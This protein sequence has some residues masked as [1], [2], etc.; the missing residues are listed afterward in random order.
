MPQ[1]PDRL[2]AQPT[3][4]DT[5]HLKVEVIKGVPQCR[6]FAV[7]AVDGGREVAVKDLKAARPLEWMEIAL[8]SVARDF[9]RLER[10]RLRRL[11]QD[12]G[13]RSRTTKAI[14]VARSAH[15]ITPEF[16]ARVAEVYRD[17]INEKPVRAVELAF[18]V[19]NSTAG[20]YV[21]RA[22]A[23]GLLPP[24]SKGRKSA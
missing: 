17:N 16:L 2:S 11:T 3:E 18:G 14:Q 8:A 21:M 20:K 13:T 5:D 4:A 6:S 15:K 7:A 9:I 10:G 19:S 12:S 24:T 22:R 1:P 23:K